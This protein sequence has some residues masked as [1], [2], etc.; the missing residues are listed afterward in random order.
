VSARAPTATVAAAAMAVALG[1][2]GSGT[3]SPR[4]LRARATALCTTAVRRSDRIPAPSSNSRGA[5]FLAQGIGIFSTELNGLRRLA[6]P[7]G[8]AGSYRVALDAARQQLDALIAAHAN[9]VRG[10]DPI[11][12]VKQLDVE[13]TAIDARDRGAWDALGAPECSNLASS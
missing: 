1:G 9:L 5:A 12:S 7:P 10:A 2:C 11:T 13:L 3:L 8:L 4:V 6:P